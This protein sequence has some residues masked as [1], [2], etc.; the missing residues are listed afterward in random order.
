MAEE[1]KEVKKVVKKEEVK[2][3][4][5]KKEKRPTALKRILQSNRRNDANRQHRSKIKTAV[6]DYATAIE[7]KE[8]KEVSQ[9]KLN[10]LFSLLDKATKK[11][12]FKKNKTD[13]IKSKYSLMF[14][15]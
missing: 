10:D 15:K 14:N 7:K 12:I 8:N 11:N 2:T 9:K 6:K 1:Q 4:E 13:R 3:E 5:K